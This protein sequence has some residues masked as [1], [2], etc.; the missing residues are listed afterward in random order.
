MRLR[1]SLFTH[2]REGGTIKGVSRLHHIIVLGL[3]CLWIGSPM[4]ACLPNSHM[5]AAEM[6]CCKKMAG[7]C[8]MGMGQHDCCKM[9]SP[10]HSPVA[11]VQAAGSHVHPGFAVEAL[12]TIFE[13]V[14]VSAGESAKVY[15]GL[16][17]PAPPGPNSIL[18]I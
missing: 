11:S 8:H 16:P 3:I 7:D 9:V 2:V 17:P 5:T 1:L 6:A 14:P 18:R 4:L 12:T 13:V 15:L 10:A